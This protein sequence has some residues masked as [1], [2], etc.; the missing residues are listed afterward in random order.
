MIAYKA[1]QLYFFFFFFL[2]L[3]SVSETNKFLM[4]LWLT[5]NVSCVG[6]AEFAF[7]IKTTM[8]KVKAELPCD[9]LHLSGKTHTALPFLPGWSVKHSVYL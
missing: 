2:A 9:H 1:Y 5:G 4:Y 6:K 8:F 7:W 3:S